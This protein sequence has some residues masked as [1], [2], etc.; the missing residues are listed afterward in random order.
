M[1]DHC[2]QDQ[3]T[4]LYEYSLL[5]A[6]SH[7]LANFPDLQSLYKYNNPYML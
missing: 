7:T 6:L 2:S 4:V 5:N 1:H 3:I